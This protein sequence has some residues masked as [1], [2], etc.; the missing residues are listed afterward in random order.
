[1]NLKRVEPEAID[2]LPTAAVAFL[3]K[4]AQHEPANEPSCQKYMNLAKVGLLDI[5]L[6]YDGE[7]LG[8]ACLSIAEEF[9]IV[10]LG[11]KRFMEWRHDFW[12]FCIK[13][14]DE[15]N[16]KIAT[17]TGRKG[18]ERVFPALKPVGVVYQYRLA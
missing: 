5:Y 14:M 12:D 6:V 4:A 8:A 1:M 15:R 10:L 13:T 17:I 16:I 3:D 18:F 11:G 7:L 2:Y 9:D